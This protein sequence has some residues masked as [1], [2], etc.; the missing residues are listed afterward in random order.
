MALFLCKEGIL[1]WLMGCTGVMMDIHHYQICLGGIRNFWLE[2][3]H[4][5]QGLFFSV[6]KLT[7]FYDWRGAFHNNPLQKIIL[8]RNFE[9]TFLCNLAHSATIFYSSS[10]S[11]NL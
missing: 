5:V 8:L 10:L 4:G 1:A 11:E 7:P 9:F 2:N 3:G 6:P